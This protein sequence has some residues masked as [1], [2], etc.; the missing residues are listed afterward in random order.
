MAANP[1]WVRPLQAALSAAHGHLR[2]G[3]SRERADR[4]V[5]AAHE[6]GWHGDDDVLWG[7]AHAMA[8]ARGSLAWVAQSGFL[9]GQIA[10]NQGEPPLLSHRIRRR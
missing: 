3:H 4:A 2:H 5:A 7:A 1:P 10:A 8:N 6:A 9:S